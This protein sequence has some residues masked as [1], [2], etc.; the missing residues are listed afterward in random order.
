MSR[1][2][3]CLAAAVIILVGVARASAQ[4]PP[5]PPP[6]PPMAPARDTPMKVGT[7]SIRG[8]VVADG[9]NA[10]LARAE[11]RI[12]SA[13]SPNG[14][15]AETD[16]NGRYELTALPAGKYTVA[17]MRPNYIRVP[18][19]QTRP[20]GLGQPLEL[21]DGQAIANINFKL[22]RAGVITGRIVDEFGDPASDVIVTVMRSQ[23]VSGERRMM[24]AG[25]ASSTNDLGDYR[26]YGLAPGQYYVSATLRSFMPGETDDRSGYAPTY[27]PGTGSVA[28]AQRITV[29]AAQ[30]VPGINL[31]LL[32]VRTA[33]ISGTAFDSA[34]KPLVGAMVMAIERQGMGMMGRAPAQVRPDGTFM[35]SGITPGTY[36]L[37][38]AVPGSDEIAV[39]AITST[40]DDVSNVQLIASKP[41]VVRGRVLI[42][43]GA[44]PPRP[45]SLRIFATQ[46]EPL[47][48]GGEARVNDDYTFEIKTGPGRLMI[49]TMGAPNDEWFL[50]G[51]RVNGVD[52]IDSGIEVPPNSVVSDVAVELTKVPTEAS[53][54]VLDANSQPIR[55]AW[56]VIFAQDA[57]R[58]TSP[59]RYVTATRPDLNNRYRVRVP[60]GDYYIVALTEIEQGEWNDP[61]F[62]LQLRDRATRVTIDEGERKTLDVTVSEAK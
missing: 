4:P 58:W 52:V 1:M 46:T 37:R 29:A 6:P 26:L 31:A 35:V 12:S 27:Y 44:T 30:T 45:S 16:G 7:A 47:M 48:G 11:I 25:R 20:N 60:P 17:A 50:H 32:P 28:E 19:G 43:R 38:V 59:S 55:D 22:Q 33:R 36:T 56:V 18:Y 21:A 13:E 39:A 54:R 10:P 40:G 34:G 57:Q 3:V 62:L 53:G 15:T 5:P 2:P 61:D 8:R 23:M 49:R 24:P 42:D 14:K 51:V 41:S 9:T